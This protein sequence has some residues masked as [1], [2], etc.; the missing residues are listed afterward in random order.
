MVA[1][2]SFWE[3]AVVG[4]VELGLLGWRLGKV[5]GTRSFDTRGL[6]DA[7]SEGKSEGERTGDEVKEG[8][9]TFS[10]LEEV[11]KVS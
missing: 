11:V 1:F 10:V 7:G 9:G 6:A 3:V 8:L 4:V 5:S 2:E